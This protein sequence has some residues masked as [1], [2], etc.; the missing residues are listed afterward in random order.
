[1]KIFDKYKE[2]ILKI[3]NITSVG[4]SNLTSN[5]ISGLFWIYLAS[6]LGTEK[7][8]ELG[9]LLAII[10]ILGGI[11]SF[12]AA[13]T[14]LVYVPKGEKIQAV[15]F[16]VVL[17]SG[18][19][20]GITS[21][22]IF[23]N[24]SILLYP[25]GYVIFSVVI[26]DLAGK[27]CFANYGKYMVLQRT[28][29]VVLSLVLYKYQGIDGIIFGYSL[30]FFPFGILMYKSF[31]ES[32]I[33]FS[34]LKGKMGFIINNYVKQILTIV[35]FN[36]DK[37]II[38]PFFGSSVLG[39]YQL[40][41]QIFVLAMLVPNVVIQ[42]TLPHDASGIKNL[43]LKKYTVLT[44]III[45]IITIS[46]S[47][48]IIPQFLPKFDESIQV[49]QIMSLSFVPQSLSILYSSELLGSGR[50]KIILIATIISIS[51]LSVGIILFGEKYGL[52]GITVSF[53]IGKIAEFLFIH[54]KKDNLKHDFRTL[55]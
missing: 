15:I 20:V 13:N 35:N 17:I 19:I 55:S 30:S 9:Y 54:I 50:T 14:L 52:F 37:L 11:A 27:K 4:I 43:K 34:I 48:I 21:Y 51:T 23:Q 26:F 1:M 5:A 22:F 18:T 24:E 3:K 36:V 47:P 16:F 29:M 7:Y 2:K 25:L 28:L 39:P 10:G 31:R 42:Y 8:G 40:G 6:L 49:I 41:F 38:F 32:K 12:G 45:T 44:S 53:V 46:L 33:D